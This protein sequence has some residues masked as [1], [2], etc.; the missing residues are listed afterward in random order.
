MSI[1]VHYIDDEL[2]LHTHMLYDKPIYDTSHT[3]VMVRTAFKD[4]LKAS[5]SRWMSTIRSSWS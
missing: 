1:T 4:G 3:A 2:T 5:T